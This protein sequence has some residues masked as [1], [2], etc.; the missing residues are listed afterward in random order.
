MNFPLLFALLL[1]I[2]KVKI[3]TYLKLND[4]GF[5]IYIYIYEIDNLLSYTLCM[6]SFP[7]SLILK[8]E[9]PSSLI[10]IINFSNAF[11]V[12]NVH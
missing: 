2:N 7:L 11:N 1:K 3:L 6:E 9:I 10:E 8:H 12:L 4:F 5:Y